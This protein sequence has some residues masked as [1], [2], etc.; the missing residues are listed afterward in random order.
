MGDPAFGDEVDFSFNEFFDIISI[1]KTLSSF[2][3]K[4]QRLVR[5]LIDSS[6]RESELQRQV[7]YR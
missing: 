1:L 6:E 2:Y 7:K 5:A 4:F 3:L